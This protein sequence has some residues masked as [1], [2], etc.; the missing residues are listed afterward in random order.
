MS[1]RPG[2]KFSLILAPPSNRPTT[3]GHTRFRIHTNSKHN[4]I[5]R[6]KDVSSSGHLLFFLDN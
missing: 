5:T 3:T 2:I 1:N 6:G 4:P